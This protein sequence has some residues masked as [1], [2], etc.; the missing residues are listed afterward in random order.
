MG[1]VGLWVLVLAGPLLGPPPASAVTVRIK[2]LDY[3]HRTYFFIADHPIEWDPASL[4]VFRDDE[5]PTNNGGTVSGRARLDPLAPTSPIQNPEYIG[6]FDVLTQGIDYDL[7]LPFVASGP[8]MIPVIQMVAPLPPQA[9]LAVSYIERSGGSTIAVGN[10]DPSIA[11]SALGKGSGEVLLKMISPPLYPFLTVPGGD[12]DPTSPWYLTLSYELRNFYRLGI[13]NF[14]W[15]DLTVRVRHLDA[16]FATDPDDFHGIPFLSL[17]G[18]DQIGPT[19]DYPPDGRV[20]PQYIDRENGILFFPDLHPFDPD[21]TIGGCPPGTAG[22]LCLDD[23]GRNPLRVCDGSDACIAKPGSL[24]P[25]PFLSG[26]IVPG[27]A[28]AASPEAK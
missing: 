19:V 21:T 14:A 28:R 22:F 9:I 6:H 15:E 11:D 13:Q 7:V 24:E 1:R 8:A 23:I 26:S 12:F 16:A 3:I 17:L 20:D 25:D 10:V 18:L 27:A 2:D 4:L 5:D